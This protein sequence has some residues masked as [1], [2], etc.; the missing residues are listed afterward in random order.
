MKNAIRRKMR[1]RNRIH[2]KAKSSEN[3]IH[4]Q[5]IWELRNEV[6]DMVRKSKEQ[7][8]LTSELTDTG[9]F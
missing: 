4:W 6:T 2:C 9:E 8:R 7:Y 1:Q 3:P 5:N